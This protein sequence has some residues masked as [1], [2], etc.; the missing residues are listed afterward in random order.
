MRIKT[1]SRRQAILDVARTVF[2][3]L[4]FESASMT[5][6]AARVGGSKATLYRYFTSKEE[7][8][9]DVMRQ[10]AE[11]LM[12]NIFDELDA[13]ADPRTNLQTFGERFLDANC[14]PELVRAYRN[15]IAESGKSSVGRLFY[16]RGPRLGLELLAIHLQRCMELGKLRRSDSLIAA[17]HL[18][19]LLKAETRESLLLGVQDS[20]PAMELPP[21]VARAVEVFLLGYAPQPTST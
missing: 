3:E 1:E 4:G 17:Q 21:M 11:N 8:F 14:Q 20:V 15:A 12:V 2:Q 5:E 19:A 16:D 6:I 10:F 18:L 7:L 13:T 9:V